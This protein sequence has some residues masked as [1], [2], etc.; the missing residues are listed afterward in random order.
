MLTIPGRHIGERQR[1]CDTYRRINQAD[2]AFR[3]RDIRPAVQ[4][5]QLA[6]IGEGLEA[7][8]ETL[9]D[10]Q[11]AQVFTGKDLTV[12]AEESCGF[13][14]KVYRHVE[15][16][17]SQAADELVFGSR[18]ILKVHAARGATTAG[19]RVIHL[20]HWQVEPDVGEFLRTE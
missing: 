4:V 14:P 12:P 11:C 7:V 15:H 18:W 10:E 20:S 16:L 2:S 5:K 8:G 9:W 6:V 13:A 17:S 19:Q 1:P 3:R